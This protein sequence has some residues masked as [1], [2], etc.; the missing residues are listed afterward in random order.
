VYGSEG[1]DD[2]FCRVESRRL[3]RGLVGGDLEGESIAISVQVETESG[4][5]RSRALFDGKDEAAVLGATQIE[6][7]VLVGVPPGVKF[8]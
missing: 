2:A 4:D 8:A 3:V 1:V 6:V 5:G 7:G